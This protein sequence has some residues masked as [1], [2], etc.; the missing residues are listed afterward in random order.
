MPQKTSVI[1]LFCED[2]REEKA[3]TTTIVGV[4]P[5]NMALLKDPPLALPRLGLYI[6]IHLDASTEILPISAKLVMP[7]GASLSLGNVDQ[8][9][10]EN[11]ARSSREANLPVT[12]VIIGGVFSPL[13][14][15]KIGK[16]LAV[17]TIGS[18]EYIAA[19]LNV[20]VGKPSATISGPSTS[21]TAS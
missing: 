7:D 13:M 5:E 12:G 19:N 21:S 11:G 4:L 15:H 16:I 10:I 6:R 2:I 1:G 3:S 18:E 14:I 9:V 8:T 17:V 20:T